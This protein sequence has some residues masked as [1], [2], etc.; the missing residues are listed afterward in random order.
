MV[1]LAL[2]EEVVQLIFDANDA[3]IWF[4]LVRSQFHFLEDATLSE[5]VADVL[6]L[7]LVF[8][9]VHQQ[10]LVDGVV[11]L[12]RIL[13]LFLELLL[14]HDLSEVQSRC[15]WNIQRLNV[16]VWRI[17]R[18][19]SLGQLSNLTGVVVEPLAVVVDVERELVVGEAH[20][21]S[22][23]HFSDELH[24]RTLRVPLHQRIVA[25]LPSELVYELVPDGFSDEKQRLVLGESLHE[26]ST[27]SGAHTFSEEAAGQWFWWEWVSSP[28]KR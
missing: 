5:P 6:G 14:S 23:L 28:R 27:V 1:V 8:A 17:G 11:A 24:D 18:N 15:L 16:I 10:G 21:Q 7:R 2:G 9:V 12:A 26:N 20:A 3:W 13:Q 22:L 19:L 25:N 4:G